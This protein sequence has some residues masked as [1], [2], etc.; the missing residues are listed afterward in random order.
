MDTFSLQDPR[1]EL[2]K[3]GFL[4]H[5]Y[6]LKMEGNLQYG[7]GCVPRTPLFCQS[8]NLHP[9]KICRVTSAAFLR[10][11]FVVRYYCASMAAREPI[12]APVFARSD[13]SGL[14]F[15]WLEGLCISHLAQHNPTSVSN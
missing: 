11:I 12:P 14:L 13:L 8:V 7:E 9:L 3:G 6:H 1:L 4:R 5:I 15:V 2:R 10:A